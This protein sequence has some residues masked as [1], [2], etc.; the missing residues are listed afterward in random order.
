MV[1]A[2]PAVHYS[3]RASGLPLPSGLVGNGITQNIVLWA[4]V[5]KNNFNISPLRGFLNTL[6]CYN[7][8]I[9]TGFEYYIVPK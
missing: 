8:V 5:I 2:S 6:L 9:P 1:N 7:N 4:G 3:P